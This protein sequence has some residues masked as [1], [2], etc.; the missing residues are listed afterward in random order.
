MTFVLGLCLVLVFGAL[1]GCL[2]AETVQ[3]AHLCAVV[4]VDEDDGAAAADANSTNPSVETGGFVGDELGVLGV[5]AGELDEGLGFEV[6]H[7]FEVESCFDQK[8]LVWSKWS[9]K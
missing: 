6:G 2:L 4:H 9:P 5:E 8:A 3:A 7:G 1:E